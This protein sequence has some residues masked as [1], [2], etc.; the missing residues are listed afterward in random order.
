VAD[1]DT[2]KMEE[3]AVMAKLALHKMFVRI[4]A[5]MFLSSFSESRACLSSIIYTLSESRSAITMPMG[6]SGG[7]S[8]FSASSTKEIL[9][10]LADAEKLF[11]A[12]L[13]CGRGRV[14]SVRN[15]TLSLALIKA[16]QTSLG[17]SEKEST[18]T[19]LNLLGMTFQK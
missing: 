7:A 2:E 8:P 6:I 17:K 4:R 5:D 13:N 11:W 12:D 16:L 15:A 18:A 9:E 3:N 14:P 1:I 10:I 19:A